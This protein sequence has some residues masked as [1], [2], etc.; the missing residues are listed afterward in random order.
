MLCCSRRTCR[1]KLSHH[2]LRRK[3][4]RSRN[5]S[6]SEDGSISQLAAA[7]S[8]HSE[9]SSWG[10]QS[11]AAC[12]AE[13]SL[14]PGSGHEQPRALRWGKPPYSPRRRPALPHRLEAPTLQLPL[15]AAVGQQQQ[16]ARRRPA[17]AAAHQASALVRVRHVLHLSRAT[18]TPLPSRRSPS[19]PAASLRDWAAAPPAKLATVPHETDRTRHE[20]HV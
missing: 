14:P 5:N 7:S 10:P 20:T 8:L 2:N 12:H 19:S 17:R 9:L 16:H 11:P 1:A 18:R 6:L 3:A 13:H 15:R 4:A